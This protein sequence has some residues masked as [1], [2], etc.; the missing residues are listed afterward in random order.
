MDEAL[1]FDTVDAPQPTH[2]THVVVRVA[3]AGWCQTDNH[4]IE[5]MWDPYVDQPLPMT[6]GMRTP[7]RSSP[8][9][10]R[11]PPSRRATR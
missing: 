5:G 9:A 8:P 2:P 6:L 10:M 1:S 4:I 3:G 11:S 7:A